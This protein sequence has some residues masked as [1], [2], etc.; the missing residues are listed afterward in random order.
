M[1]WS[2]RPI[3]YFREDWHDHTVTI[4]NRA[5]RAWVVVAGWDLSRHLH[6]WRTS[7]ALSAGAKAHLV[8]HML[9]IIGVPEDA[10][11][12]A[13]HDLLDPI[14]VRALVLHPS[15]EIVPLG[16]EPPV[17]GPEVFGG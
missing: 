15:L 11:L 4:E 1:K 3:Y 5:R 16:V 6:L 8:E 13:F 12:V 10:V 14:G 17:V 9:R 2:A 7:G